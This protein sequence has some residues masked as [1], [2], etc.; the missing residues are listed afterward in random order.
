MNYFELFEIPV[1]F[2]LDTVEL[3]RKYYVLSKTFHPDRFTLK[4][5]T[6]QLLA[7]NQSTE[8]NKAYRTLKERQSRIR[9]ILELK[10]VIFV[11]GQEKVPQDF[12]MEMMEI[13]ESLMELKLD[14]EPSSIRRIEKQIEEIE[15]SLG[16]EIS[17]VMELIDLDNPD[18]SKLEL[19]K[20]YYLKTK[21]LQRLRENLFN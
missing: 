17:A 1:S 6:E 13:N 16:K 10:G 9:Y 20:I 12:L 14:P 3:K 11:E 18:E 21:Y 19:V 8:I 15:T 4:S 7:L 2:E 5:E